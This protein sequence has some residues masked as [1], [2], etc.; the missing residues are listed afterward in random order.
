MTKA[1]QTFVGDE[2]G[3]VTLDFVVLT[4]AIALMSLTFIP[5]LRGG[6]TKIATEVSTDMQAI[7]PGNSATF[8]AK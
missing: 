3:A 4:A 2:D 6:A 8:V 1:I 7:D 5:A